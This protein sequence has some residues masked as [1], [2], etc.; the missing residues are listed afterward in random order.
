ML[1]SVR[2]GYLGAV[3]VAAVGARE[4]PRPAVALIDAH[5]PQLDVHPHGSPTKPRWGQTGRGHKGTGGV[6]GGGNS[7]GR[8]G[9]RDTEASGEV[10]PL[11]RVSHPHVHSTAHTCMHSNTRVSPSIPKDAHTCMQ[12][13][14][15]A[16]THVHAHTFMHSHTC[17]HTHT[18]AQTRFP[19]CTH[20]QTQMHA[21]KYTSPFLPS[22]PP[23]TH[24]NSGLRSGFSP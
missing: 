6:A 22:P 13:H 23:L 19:T 18:A 3:E 16:C 24:L 9:C 8:A 11:G 7:G 4:P 5:I 10:L 14:M 21:H 20:T 12:S 15:H 17:T 2:S 1:G